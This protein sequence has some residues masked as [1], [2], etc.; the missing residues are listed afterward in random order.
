MSLRR[1]FFSLLVV[2]FLSSSTAFA[3]EASYEQHIAKGISY[4]ETN[5][6]IDAIEEFRAAIRE[7][8]DDERATLYLGI[9]LSRSK[10]KEAET[11]LKKAL[12]INPGEPRTNLELGIYYFNKSIFEEAKDYFENT[13]KLAPNTGFSLKAEEYLK[14]IRSRAAMPGP[15]AMNI[16][17]G[18]QYDSNV[19]LESENG[20]LPQGISRKSDWSG[21][22]Y[23]KGQHNFLR[24][25]NLNG[26]VSYSLYQSLHARLTDFDITQHLIE[27]K[28]SS[29]VLPEVS[30]AARYS[31]EY[32]FLG[33]DDYDFSH[34]L[35]PSLII[36]EGKGFST[37]IEYQYRKKHFINTDIFTDNSDRT[38]SNN[39]I[40]ITQHIPVSTSITARIGYS[41]DEDSTRKDYWDYKGDKGFLGI[42][43]NMP[44]RIS[45]DFYGEYYSKNYEGINYLISSIKREDIIHTYSA[46][47]T[48]ALTDRYCITI[49]QSHINNNSNID[50]YDYKRNISTLFFTARF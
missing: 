31:F 2:S 33:G 17:A 11:T 39:L 12:S 23:L 4:L 13:I 19:V 29:V 32:L 43:F 37:A 6:Y 27:L 22:I 1:S 7:K 48:K 30:L 26:S 28:A 15:W 40:G 8:P 3:T 25:D 16:S 35:A 47:L 38:G 50:P 41:L 42:K 9:T 45:L 36:S 5:N 49:G 21:I 46:S 44:C 18:I 34:T 14:A 24:S 20:T 10:D